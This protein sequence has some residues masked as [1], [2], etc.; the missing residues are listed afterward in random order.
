MQL[1]LYPW[2]IEEDEVDF[3]RV[4]LKHGFDLGGSAKATLD[5][6]NLAAYLKVISALSISESGHLRH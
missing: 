4:I 6:H 1:P 2:L 5:R 3:A